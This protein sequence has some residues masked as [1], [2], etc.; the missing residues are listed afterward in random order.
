MDD[1]PWTKKELEVERKYLVE[2]RIAIMCDSGIPLEEAKKLAEQDVER[3]HPWL[4]G[5]E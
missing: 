4:K 1:F 3:S 2:E 5:A